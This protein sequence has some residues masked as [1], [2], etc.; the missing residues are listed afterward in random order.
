[1]AEQ[2][3]LTT[4]GIAIRFM[5]FPVSMAVLLFVPAGR[6]DL[7]FFWAYVL[8]LLGYLVIVGFFVMDADLRRERLRPGQG[9]DRLMRPLALPFS[10][11]HLVIAGFD[12]GRYHF[13]DTIP[14][15]ARIA[16]LAGLV[17]VL[18][19]AAWAISANR[20]FSPVVRIQEDRGHT[21]VTQG[22]YRF[23]RH[24]GYVAGLGMLVCSGLSLGSWW[25]MAPLV[26]PAFL[27]LRR[28]ILEDRFLRRELPGYADYA[29]RVRY[30]L[31]PG[32]W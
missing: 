11:A 22:P 28:T 20:F 10:M 7:P 29:S 5:A 6:I 21:L 32:I 17:L 4:T 2:K 13:S 15:D 31:L 26:V 8:I 16:G 12:V 18:S 24:P 3:P 1:M 19:L 23:I 30:R 27:M 14:T 25:A 9:E